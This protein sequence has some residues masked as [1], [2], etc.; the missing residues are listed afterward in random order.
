MNEFIIT[1][2]WGSNGDHGNRDV[3]E[4]QIAVDK[5]NK[6]IAGK[7]TLIFPKMKFCRQTTNSQK[8]IRIFR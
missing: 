4:P 6:R 5:L 1:K 3:I 8:S 2:I 7:Q